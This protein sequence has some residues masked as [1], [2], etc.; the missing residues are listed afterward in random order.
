MPATTPEEICSLFKRYMAEGD[1]ESLLTV[2]DPEVVFLNEAGEVKKGRTE[3]KMCWLR[4]PRQKRSS[5]SI[6]S[7]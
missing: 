2:Y 5:T 1:L 3:S 4:W 6:S 7:K